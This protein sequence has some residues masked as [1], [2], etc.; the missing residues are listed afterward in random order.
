M[1]KTIDFNDERTWPADVLSY[2]EQNHD[3]FLDWETRTGSSGSV[4]PGQYDNA[5]HGLRAVLNNHELHG[6]HCTRLTAPEIR[7]II[8][9]GMQLPNAALLRSRIQALQLDGLINVS[10]AE[11]LMAKNQADEANRANRIWFCFFAPRLAGQSGIDCLLGLW[12]GEALYN[13]HERNPDTG[14]ILAKL[15]VPCLVEADIAIANLRG[16]SFLDIKA[17]KQFLKWRG[18]KCTEPMEHEDC[19]TCDVPAAKIRRI[20]QFPEA[21]FLALTGCDT[22]SPPLK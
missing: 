12:G 7:H 20:I 3:L 16:P 14:P 9:S 1:L 19:T 22:W 4:T 18:F 6:Y 10:V 13:T 11:R 15:G 2:L 5:L 8:S 17:A 21:D